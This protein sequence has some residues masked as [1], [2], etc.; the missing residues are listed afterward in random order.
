MAVR[1]MMIKYV[2]CY[3]VD[4]W[5][6]RQGFTW[7][8]W[9]NLAFLRMAITAAQEGLR[10]DSGGDY[11]AYGLH[12][13][14]LAVLF[15]GVVFVWQTVGV[16]RA[17]EAHIRD[18]GSMANVWGAQLGILIAFWL[19]AS[20]A[21][22]SWQMTLPVSSENGFAERMDRERAGKYRIDASADGLTL[23]ISGTVELGITR[24][25]ATWLE[26]S[27]H[28]RTIALNSAG[29]NIYE[30]R[31]LSKLISER[32]LDTLVETQCS[33]AC[34]IVFIGGA[35]RSLGRSARLGFHQYRID[36]DYDV[37]LADPGGEQERDRALYAARNVKPWF[38]AKMFER[39]GDDIWFPSRDELVSAGVVNS[40]AD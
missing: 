2:W 22:D 9:V 10:P 29:G 1:D 39:G 3:L 20:Y 34:T 17:G 19:T 12:V 35:N 24:K 36:A 5:Q 30:A 32:Q 18:R 38:L 7:S 4:H 16:L 11:S 23:T 25:F 27:P 26:R 31:G 21:F 33:S 15:H 40:P 14:G 8:F 37:L 6:G 13:F 28:A